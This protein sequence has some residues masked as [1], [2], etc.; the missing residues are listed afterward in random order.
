MDEGKKIEAVKPKTEKTGTPFLTPEQRDVL[1][2]LKIKLQSATSE[3]EKQRLI[4]MIQILERD[5][6]RT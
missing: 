5:M 3:E 2:K 4:E 1:R 6:K